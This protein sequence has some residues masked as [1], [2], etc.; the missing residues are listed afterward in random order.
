MGQHAADD[1]THHSVSSG[2]GDRP[3]DNGWAIWDDGRCS[4][5]RCLELPVAAIERAARQRRPAHWQPYC[6]EHA[7]ARGVEREGDELVWTAAYLEP[8][9]RAKDARS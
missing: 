6:E 3:Q 1:E 9:G 2:G 7:R 4:I 8:S 5:T